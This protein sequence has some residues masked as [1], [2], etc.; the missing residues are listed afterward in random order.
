MAAPLPIHTENQHGV[1]RSWVLKRILSAEEEEELVNGKVMAI[2]ERGYDDDNE[3]EI[4]MQC[5]TS[6]G[7]SSGGEDNMEEFTQFQLDET[8]NSRAAILWCFR[9]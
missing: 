6:S 8:N 5:S 1:F 2:H 9:G 3:E 4:S 7:E